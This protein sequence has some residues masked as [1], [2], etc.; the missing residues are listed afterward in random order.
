MKKVFIGLIIFLS[1][2]SWAGTAPGYQCES[3]EMVDFFDTKIPA[4]TVTVKDIGSMFATIIVSAAGTIPTSLNS[5]VSRLTDNGS[6]LL[7]ATSKRGAA[8][9]LNK[10]ELLANFHMSKKLYLE[11]KSSTYATGYSDVF[12]SEDFESEMLCTKPIK[13]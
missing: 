13:Y 1:T 2:S 12:N 10:T 6:D 11:V 4:F 5:T 3:K 8:V 7:S 9:Y